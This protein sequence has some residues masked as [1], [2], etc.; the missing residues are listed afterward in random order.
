MSP[1]TLAHSLVA[2]VVMP[3]F[4][5]SG[6]DTP[7]QALDG[8][9]T[10]ETIC[11]ACHTLNPPPLKAPPMT[12]VSRRYRM[13]FASESLGVEAITAWI[14]NPDTARSHMPAMAIERFGL[15]APLPLPEAQRRAVARYVWG[16]ATPGSLPA[17]KPR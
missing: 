13:T 5:A 2:A 1:R 9:T 7:P 6:Q 12:H 14:A 4:A 11:A 8:R 17:P 3:V 15:M 10:F 16:L